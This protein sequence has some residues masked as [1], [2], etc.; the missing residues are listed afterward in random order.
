[1]TSQI[2]LPLAVTVHAAGETRHLEIA[3]RGMALVLAALVAAGGDWVSPMGTGIAGPTL[4]KRVAA[5]RSRYRL[6]VETETVQDSHTF[7]NRHR[8]RQA[9]VIE[10]DCMKRTV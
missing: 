10:A 3:N 4:N 1:M 6:P 9:V 8:L 7:W 5:L 2:G